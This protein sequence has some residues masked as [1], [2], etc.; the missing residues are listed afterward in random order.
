MNLKPTGTNVVI[1]PTEELL[2]PTIIVSD[3]NKAPSPYGRVIA[4]GP[5]VVDLRVGDEVFCGR[6]EGRK[7]QKTLEEP[8]LRIMPEAAVLGKFESP[9]D[10]EAARKLTH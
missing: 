5:K 2:S 8:E 4:V 10:L 7:Y 6:Y 3:A 1:Q 9:D